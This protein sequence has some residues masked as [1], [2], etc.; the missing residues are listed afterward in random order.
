MALSWE[1]IYIY[2][3]K[4]RSETLFFR[5][6]LLVFVNYIAVLLLSNW[7]PMLLNT[8]LIMGAEAGLAALSY[9]WQK[10]SAYGKRLCR[11]CACAWYWAMRFLIRI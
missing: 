2:L 4:D 6:I 10:T 7:E 11:F 1:G 8:Y 3:Q 9:Y 5:W